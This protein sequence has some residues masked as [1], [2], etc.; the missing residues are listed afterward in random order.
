[1]EVN[2]LRWQ[3][4]YASYMFCFLFV[5]FVVRTYL[6]LKSVQVATTTE[7]FNGKIANIRQKMRPF[8]LSGR[9]FWN[10]LSSLSSLCHSDG[11]TSDAGQYEVLATKGNNCVLRW[12]QFRSHWL[13]DMHAWHCG[14]GA[15]G[16]MHMHI[17]CFLVVVFLFVWFV[18]VC[19][20]VC[21]CVCVCVCY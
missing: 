16:T 2:H 4:N 18:C 12:L 13:P 19:V 17:S 14:W 21:M 9:C 10:F 6:S 20:C 1:M 11:N 3:I 8:F 7:V 15:E 5:A